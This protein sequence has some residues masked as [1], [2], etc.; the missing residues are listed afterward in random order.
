MDIKIHVIG[1]FY[2]G[3]STK[4]SAPL[5]V[6]HIAWPGYHYWLSAFTR[7]IV[8]HVNTYASVT[9]VSILKEDVNDW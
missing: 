2:L 1:T 4:P 5:W 7:Y 8:F 6:K 9:E 3:L